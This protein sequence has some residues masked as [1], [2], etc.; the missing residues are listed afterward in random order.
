MVSCRAR[1]CRIRDDDDADGVMWWMHRHGTNDTVDDG[2]M[3]IAIVHRGEFE[4]VRSRSCLQQ[5][6]LSD[7]DVVECGVSGTITRIAAACG[8]RCV[9]HDERP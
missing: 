6:A 9:R 2:G 8:W 7:R 5:E 3:G 4:V 1:Q